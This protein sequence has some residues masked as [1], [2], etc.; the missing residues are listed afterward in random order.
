MQLLVFPLGIQLPLLVT[1]VALVATMKAPAPLAASISKSICKTAS[2]TPSTPSLL[3]GAWP[4]K[5]RRKYLSPNL[6]GNF[7][8]CQVK[9]ALFC[10][11]WPFGHIGRIELKRWPQ[12]SS[13]KLNAKHRELLELQKQAQARLARTR[14]RFSEGM[15]DAREVRNDLEWTQKKVS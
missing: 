3:I 14:E 5:H 8:F 2:L 4:F 15:R 10:P 11:A 13:G 12:T 9:E 6:I 7:F 1:S